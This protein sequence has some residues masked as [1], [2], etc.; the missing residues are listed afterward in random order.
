MK[1]VGALL[2]G[3]ILSLFAAPAAMALAEMK[4]AAVVADDGDRKGKK[5]KHGKKDGKKKG[6]K[7]GKKHG[8]KHEGVKKKHKK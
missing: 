6:K 2:I 7:K 8:K 4:P 1:T 3:L 5:G